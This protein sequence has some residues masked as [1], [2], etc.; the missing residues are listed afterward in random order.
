MPCYRGCY[1]LSRNPPCFGEHGLV[2]EPRVALR[3]HDRRVPQQLLKGGD[4]T[5]PLDPPASERVSQLMGVK[6]PCLAQDPHAG[7]ELPR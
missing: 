6:A 2:H 7:V 3:R 1:R 5:T 4:A